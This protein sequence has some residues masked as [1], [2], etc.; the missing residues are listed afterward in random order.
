MLEEAASEGAV[1]AKALRL[2][3]GLRP[4]KGDFGGKAGGSGTP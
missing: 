1:T 3:A 2:A 4:R